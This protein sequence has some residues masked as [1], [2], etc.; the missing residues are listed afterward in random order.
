MAALTEQ[1][2]VMG[3]RQALLEQ[4]LAQRPAAAGDPPGPGRDLPGGPAGVGVDTRL[5]GK[6]HDSSSKLDD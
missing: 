2:R 4:E 5:L 3:E 6:S 1:L